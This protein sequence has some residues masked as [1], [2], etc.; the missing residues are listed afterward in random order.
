ME[1]QAQSD[2]YMVGLEDAPQFYAWGGDTKSAFRDIELRRFVKEKGLLEEERALKDSHYALY[3]Y[4][5]G[6]RLY[7][8]L[9]SLLEGKDFTYMRPPS[10]RFNATATQI[11]T[12]LKTKQVALRR[13]QLALMELK[14]Y[15]NAM[16]D[17][18]TEELYRV[19][20]GETRDPLTSAHAEAMKKAH[21]DIDSLH[22]IDDHRPSVSRE[23]IACN[24]S[25]FSAEPGE[26][27]WYFWHY[28]DNVHHLDKEELIAS[29][30]DH[31][32]IGQEHLPELMELQQMIEPQDHAMIAVYLPKDPDLI[33][34]SVYVAQPFGEPSKVHQKASEV[35]A[36]LQTDPKHVKDLAFLQMRLVV[37]NDDLLNPDSG[38]RVKVFDEIGQKRLASYQERLAKWADSLDLRL[39]A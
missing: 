5:H 28:R 35:L 10:E 38:I 14:E 1:I 3:H 31:Y 30:L 37:R 4:A 25:I 11:A 17:Q 15:L 12:E 39:V 2:A 16:D 6:M 23:L 22:F 8:D 7:R 24:P 29:V 34:R 20:M 9:I 36:Q 27:A 18:K 19:F 32:G 21:K 13:F 33:D 26:S